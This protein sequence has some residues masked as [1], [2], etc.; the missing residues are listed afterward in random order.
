MV[1]FNALDMVLPAS[2]MAKVVK[3]NKETYRENN[4]PDD[5]SPATEA[6]D[7]AL[8]VSMILLIILWICLIV[9]NIQLIQKIPQEHGGARITTIIF[10]I[11]GIFNP[12]FLVISIII[13]LFYQ[14]KAGSQDMIGFY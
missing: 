2:A 9:V 14:P 7:I 3:N 6:Q 8:I 10:L 5:D 13:A 12:L 4:G 11:L 1:Q